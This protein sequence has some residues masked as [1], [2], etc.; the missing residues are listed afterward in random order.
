MC[1]AGGTILGAVIV[2]WMI[3]VAAGGGDISD[4]GGGDGDGE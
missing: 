3:G 2:G 4:Y 1:A